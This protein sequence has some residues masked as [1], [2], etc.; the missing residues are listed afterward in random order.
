MFGK[1]KAAPAAKPAPDPGSYPKWL[2]D[3]RGFQAIARGPKEEAAILAGRAVYSETHS[4][5][6][7]IERQFI[8]EE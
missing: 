7:G 4:A 5:Q 1:K 3:P 6:Q 8:G 2:K